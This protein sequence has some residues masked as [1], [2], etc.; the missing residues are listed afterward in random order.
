MKRTFMY[1]QNFQNR[2]W[3]FP[4]TPDTTPVQYDCTCYDRLRTGQMMTD[5]S[6]NKYK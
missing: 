6:K 5:R 4:A 2:P 1:N 3:L